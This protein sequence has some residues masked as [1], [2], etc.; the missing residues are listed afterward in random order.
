MIFAAY[1]MGVF[2]SAHSKARPGWESNKNGGAIN[3]L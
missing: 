1:P 2:L 3:R